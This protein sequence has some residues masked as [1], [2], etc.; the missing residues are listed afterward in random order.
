VRCAVDARVDPADTPAT[1]LR[2]LTRAARKIVYW[3]KKRE[4]SARS[5]YKR[6]L[7]KLH[8]HGLR[9]SEL[10]KCSWGDIAL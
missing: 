10:R 8:R 3:Q 5:H 4:H 2:K 1:R 7:R 6:R 9:L